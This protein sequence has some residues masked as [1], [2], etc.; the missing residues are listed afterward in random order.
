MPPRPKDVRARAEAVRKVLDFLKRTE[1]PVIGIAP[2]GGDSPDGKLARPASG[3]GRFGLLLAASGLGFV[4]AGIHEADGGICLRFGPAYK[5]RVAASLSSAEKD[6][7]AATIIMENIARLL[8]E[9]LRGEFE[10]RQ[11]G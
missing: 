7:A 10:H 2:E 8:P 9:H 5:L 3:S 11:T 6:H 4:P 1:R